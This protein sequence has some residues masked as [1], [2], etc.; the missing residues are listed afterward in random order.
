[1]PNEIKTKTSRI[2]YRGWTWLV[3]AFLLGSFWGA[4]VLM[5]MR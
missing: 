5:V 3:I 1:M 4:L 2:S